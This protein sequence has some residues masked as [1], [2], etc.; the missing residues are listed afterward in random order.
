MIETGI[1]T[2]LVYIYSVAP[3]RAFI[4]CG[5]LIEGGYIATCRHVWHGAKTRGSPEVEIEFPAA[6][7]DGIPCRAGLADA[8]GGAKR[9][10]AR[11]RAAET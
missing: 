11:S 4:G 1:E 10:S 2:G 5:A 8:C 6:E 7:V 3:A 9:A